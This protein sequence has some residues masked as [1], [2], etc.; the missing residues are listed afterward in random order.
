[1]KT[2]S[3]MI[4]TLCVPCGNRCRYCLLSWNGHTVG[5]DYDRSR[6][7]AERFIGWLR[8]SR[9][10]LTVHFSFGYSME[11]PRLLEAVDFMRSVGS[12]GGEYLQFDGMAFRTDG[13]L[14][15][16]IAGLREHGV[17]H[18]NF[19][20]YGTE[21]Y[22]DAF[23]GRKGDF[24][25]LCR[26]ARICHAAGVRISAGVPL[27]RENAAQAGDLLRQLTDEGLEE[28]RFFV[29]H[30]EGRGTVLEPVRLRERDVRTLP[31][32]VAARFNRDAFRTE[33]EWMRPGAFRPADNRTL[34]LSLTPE[35]IGDLETQD[36]ADTIAALEALDEAYYQTVPTIEAL[37]DR[38]G[39]PQGEC[40][41]SQRDLYQ[42]WQK[43][44][45]FE[46]GLRPYDVTDERQSGSRRF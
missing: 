12:V 37:S 23:A 18:I 36:P 44:F 32:E 16:L 13:E 6:R 1:M 41:Y 22:H 27:T 2:R 7:Y 39:D 29:P 5:A 11:H 4:Q 17:K 10:D 15:T 35:N 8:S 25:L 9:P 19:T 45:L 38:Y 46:T 21:S 31:P 33:A 40:L 34:L 24:D 28:I 30:G 20:F 14:E 42:K 43:Q 26:T 3:I